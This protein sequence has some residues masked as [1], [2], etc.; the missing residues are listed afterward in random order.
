MS[1]YVMIDIETLDTRDSAIVLSVAT[2]AFN[3]TNLQTYNELKDSSN[4]YYAEFN[5]NEQEQCGRTIG[6]NTLE[7]WL[8]QPNFKLKS[9][10]SKSFALPTTYFLNNLTQFIEIN[11]VDGIWSNGP[12]FDMII[13]KSLYQSFNI[14]FRMDYRK[15]LDF[16]TIKKINELVNIPKINF[17]GNK[18][19]AIDDAVNQALFVNNTL[20]HIKSL[21]DQISNLQKIKLTDHDIDSKYD[22]GPRIE[23]LDLIYDLNI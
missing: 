18:H 4:I 14:E 1:N 22:G 11:G 2:C 3:D 21:N 17:I 16:R 13:L 5:I 8:K 15:W 12:S 9:K 19:D 7:W 23:D 6:L 20:M 10:D